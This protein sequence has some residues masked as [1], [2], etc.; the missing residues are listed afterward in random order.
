MPEAFDPPAS[1]FFHPDTG[2]EAKDFAQAQQAAPPDAVNNNPACLVS[3]RPDW[4]AVCP[5][6][7]VEFEP[8]SK[9][10]KLH[11]S[12]PRGAFPTQALSYS[13][14]IL[15]LASQGFPSI[16]PALGQY[17]CY[18]QQLTL[19]TLPMEHHTHPLSRG[20]AVELGRLVCPCSTAVPQEPDGYERLI[21]H[22]PYY[23]P[24]QQYVA[25]KTSLPLSTDVRLFPTYHAWEA[26][27]GRYSN[28]NVVRPHE[29]DGQ[30]LFGPEPIT[31]P[32]DAPQNLHS[33]SSE[34]GADRI[35]ISAYTTLRMRSG[36]GRG[37]ESVDP[38]ETQAFDKKRLTQGE[39][40]AAYDA[41][42]K[43]YAQCDKNPEDPDGIC[44]TCTKVTITKKG[45]LPC[46][47]Y[48]IADI[49][50]YKSG[51]VPGFE[52][53]KRWSNE[54]SDPIDTWA[55]SEIRTIKVSGGYSDNF[56]EL[57]VRRF[58]P[59]EGDKLVRTWDYK[60]V[61][62]SA[63]IPPFALVDAQKARKA[64]SRHIDACIN[65]ALKKI[66]GPMK[67][68]ATMLAK[69]YFEAYRLALKRDIPQEVS[70]ILHATFRLWTS[71]R[72]NTI[73]SFIVGD[74]TLGM[75]KDILDETS[76]TPGKVPL[77][78]VM[79]AQLNLIMIHEIQAKLRKTVL[80]QLQ[81]I[82]QKNKHSTWLVTYFVDFILLHNAS[83]IIA[84]DA[85]YAKK[86]GI[87]RRFARED[88]VKEYHVGAN[89]VL[90]YFHYCNKGMYP[91]SAECNESELRSLAEL[92][93]HE[94]GLVRLTAA[95]ARA[96]EMKWQR[97]RES[98][99]YD[100]PE[101]YISQMFEQNWKPRSMVV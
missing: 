34:Y 11:P 77:P 85:G 75:P 31:N 61:K 28:Q 60:G 88:K 72:L 33:L 81:K 30:Q 73:S 41:E 52:W 92:T 67:G 56:V 47:R 40:D 39:L 23:D 8:A 58:V 84:H 10:R 57:Q 90:A 35:P 95:Y 66:T 9:R 71:T 45:Q 94:L 83:M 38:S 29:F 64:F 12:D 22:Q 13:P 15:Q 89:I 93:E 26:D 55:S 20:W 17:P 48:K 82:V 86:H 6:P 4:Y 70:N 99:E 18:S 49:A 96:R 2:R 27:A 1:H 62:K 97:L 69:T 19:A 7:I 63:S 78:P 37:Q 87:S 76:P 65:D 80:D 98:E 68:S 59:L 53:T 14:D 42:C 3:N 54:L 16:C 74:D 79:G 46:L 50:L 51:E 32:S 100:D 36:A 21:D 5:D 91:F 25:E 24:N 43:E 101:Y 44:L